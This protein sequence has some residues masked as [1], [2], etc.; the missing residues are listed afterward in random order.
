[1][2]Q[3]SLRVTD[4]ITYDSRQHNSNNIQTFPLQTQKHCARYFILDDLITLKTRDDEANSTRLFMKDSKKAKAA[5][6]SKKPKT[7]PLNV[8]QERFC[9]L[10]AG[11]MNGT[12]AWIEAGYPVSR[13]VAAANAS[14]ALGNP[15]IKSRIDQLR[16]PQTKAA[17][18]SKEEKLAFLAEIVR[19]PVG[20]VG[21]DSPLCQEFTEE[22]VGGGRRG[23]LRRGHA[24]SGNETVGPIITRTR[25]KMADKLRALELHAKISGDF[26]PEK[27]EHVV[28]A[29]AETLATL[30]ERAKA[31]RSA[32]NL[33][34]VIQ[35]PST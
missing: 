8:R 22:I 17:L 27:H 35:P 18:L 23:K 25:S 10:V 30:Q 1:M 4:T 9:E 2:I 19:T 14:E 29:G 32:L 7:R 15:K 3:H 31:V 5:K 13:T 11:G 28:E 26:A 24:N 33:A 6:T 16:K 12:E 20:E 34:P 21:P